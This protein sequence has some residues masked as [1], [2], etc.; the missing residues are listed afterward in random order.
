MVLRPTEGV[1]D[2]DPTR[3]GSLGGGRRMGG[4]LQSN[5]EKRGK[6]GLS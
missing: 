6:S 1:D 4:E 2:G 5:R 3:S